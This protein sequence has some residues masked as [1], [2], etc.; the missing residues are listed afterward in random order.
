MRQDL[1]SFRRGCLEAAEQLCFLK[2][3]PCS[4]PISHCF[5]LFC[6][7]RCH[8]EVC[9]RLLRSRWHPH[10]AKIK[11]QPKG[12]SEASV[13]KQT[14]TLLEKN[15]YI[16]IYT[17][18]IYKHVHVHVY[19]CFSSFLPTPLF[20]RHVTLPHPGALDAVGLPWLLPP[21]AGI[22]AAQDEA[23][24]SGKAAI[25]LGPNSI[26]P[27]GWPRDKLDILETCEKMCEVIWNHLLCR[28]VRKNIGCESESI[29]I[30]P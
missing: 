6:G 18:Y 8:W 2:K 22:L 1:L 30:G 24:A 29:E 14:Y 11:P 28:E 10:V 13:T 26:G 5:F 7:L 9:Q 20:P 19:T 25:K 17:T 27:P 3:E 21:S 16:Y 4:P 12:R 23:G 15:I